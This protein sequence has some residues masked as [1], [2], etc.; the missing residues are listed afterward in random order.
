MSVFKIDNLRV[1]GIRQV[2]QWAGR[3]LYLPTEAPHFQI[4]VDGKRYVFGAIHKNA[5]SSIRTMIEAISP[6]QRRA[7]ESIFEFLFRNHLARNRRDFDNADQVMIF[8]RHPLDRV[9]SCFQNKF[10]QRKSNRTIFRDYEQV[11]GRNPA[12]ATFEQFV[13]DY[14]RACLKGGAVVGRRRDRHIYTQYQQLLPVD[15]D[16]VVRV[17]QF[18]KWMKVVGLSNLLPDRANRT[19]N[20]AGVADAWVQTSEELYTRYLED[21][22]TPNKA[23]LLND[24]LMA[25]I[26]H[27]YRADLQTF[28]HLLAGAV[29]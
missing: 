20:T 8:V 1:K 16:V 4:Q 24:A 29:P 3:S 27:L 13:Y 14:L 6:F 23:S 18:D 12:K 26:N 15:Y 28:G 19:W 22:Q 11:T 2:K 21:G 7:N 10:V 5:S 9:V 25:E 17:E